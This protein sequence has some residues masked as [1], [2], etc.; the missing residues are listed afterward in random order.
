VSNFDFLK[1]YALESSKSSPFYFSTLSV[2]KCFYRNFMSPAHCK[3]MRI[4]TLLEVIREYA[5][6]QLEV[7]G[8]EDLYQ[9]RH[10]EYYA[11]LAEEAERVGQGQGSGEAHLDQESGNGRAALHWANARGDVALGLGWLRGLDCSG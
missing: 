6:E 11:E 2:R 5:I 1:F 9:R 3:D 8:D 4:I 10:A 7:M